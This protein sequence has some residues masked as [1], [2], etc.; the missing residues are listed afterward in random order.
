MW[1]KTADGWKRI[2]C[3][4]AIPAPADPP[5]HNLLGWEERGYKSFLGWIHN[6]L[7]MVDPR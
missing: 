5:A 4:N 6:D 2:V 3:A 1:I 7:D